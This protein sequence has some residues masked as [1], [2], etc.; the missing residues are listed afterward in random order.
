M[1][2]AFIAITPPEALHAA[3]QEVRTAFD[4]QA[5]S[6]RWIPPA[7]VHLTLKFLGDV[8]AE[9]VPSL[10]QAMERVAEE[11]GVF[12]LLVRNLGCF[13]SLSRPRV[14]WMGLE[15]PGGALPALHARLEAE[16][17]ALGFATEERPF[18]P[19]L[20]LARTRQRVDSV[21]L[22]SFLQSYQGQ[23]FGALAV[24][25]LH[26]YQ[27]DLHPQGAVYTVLHTVALQG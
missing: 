15:D 3:M 14:L 27:S 10:V 18:R 9:A 13:P 23:H 8:A 24:E 4:R 17:A 11:Q 20:T 21:Q 16:L 2:R 26:L 22:G 19:H 1:I 7:N 6:W 25:H 5:R 12:S